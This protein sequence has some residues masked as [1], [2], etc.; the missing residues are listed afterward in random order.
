MIFNH[1]MN[2]EYTLYFFPVL[3]TLITILVIGSDSLS[4]IAGL[5]ISLG[6]TMIKYTGFRCTY[7]PFNLIFQTKLDNEINSKIKILYSVAV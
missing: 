5:C 3:I 7:S 2:S 1:Y 6:A 4:I